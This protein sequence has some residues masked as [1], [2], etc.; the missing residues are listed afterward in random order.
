MWAFLT[1]LTEKIFE[2]IRDIMKKEGCQVCGCIYIACKEDNDFYTKLIVRQKDIQK[3]YI[4]KKCKNIIA[5]SATIKSIGTNELPSFS[6][7]IVYRTSSLPLNAAEI[8]FLGACS[9]TCSVTG[10]GCC[11]SDSTLKIWL[12]FACSGCTELLF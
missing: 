4:D 3:K 11:S 6:S 2:L 7:S 5:I 1:F 10:C 12:K 8:C 9:S